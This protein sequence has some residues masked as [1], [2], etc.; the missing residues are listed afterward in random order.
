MRQHA[1]SR[2]RPV[3]AI[4]GVA[5]VIAFMAVFAISAPVS[6]HGD[7]DDPLE[8]LPEGWMIYDGGALLDLRDFDGQQVP[9]ELA[10]DFF[11]PGQPPVRWSTVSSPVVP[12][13][14]HQAG[15]PS[16]LTADQFREA[17]RKGVAVWSEAEAAIGLNYTGDCSSGTTWRLENN[18][19]EIGWD[20]ARGFVRSPAAGITS[21]AWTSTT[22]RFFEADIVLH[23]NLDLPMECF[24][25]VVAHEL[26]HVLGL[27]HSTTPGHLMY[28]S[29][30][31][32]DPVTC[33]GRPSTEE[34][35]ILQGI[36]GQ[37]R[38]PVVIAPEAQ[39]VVAGALSTIAVSAGDPDGDTISYAWTQTAGPTVTL[40]SDAATAT[41]TAPDEPGASL[42]FSVA[43]RDPYRHTT[44]AS[45]Q[46]EVID[47]GRAP[48]AP[49]V[50]DTFSLSPDGRRMSLVFTSEPRASEYRICTRPQG[51]NLN[52]CRMQATPIVEVTWDWVLGAPV[53]N[54][55]RRIFS[56]GIREVTIQACNPEGCS[57]PSEGNPMAGG[58][59]W[60]GHNIDFDYFAMSFDEGPGQRFSIALVQNVSS[61]ARAFQL[62]AGEV[63]THRRAL[64]QDCG[65]IAAG[66]VC[67]GFLGPEDEAH[68]THVTVVSRRA[69]T[70]ETEHR[71]RVR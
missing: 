46:V 20:D 36:Y 12:I 21:G 44:T 35:E 47:A 49:P 57:A 3:W 53:E 19:N 28:A 64:M 61:T 14:S 11:A 7:S 34:I 26:G 40:T 60:S 58:L 17:V 45:M 51:T 1:A 29:F 62:Y 2:I 32:S 33:P 10:I 52:A 5:L 67:M 68:G 38:A 15:R 48:S 56:G 13:C 41:F 59:R 25:S 16:W 71:I 70:V 50:L 23:R 9:L 69:G 43:V 4:S 24:D 54:E 66:D 6:A 30:N 18:V 27:G 55:P 37:N 8:D 31:P 42:E 39:T 63:G 65:V 22:R